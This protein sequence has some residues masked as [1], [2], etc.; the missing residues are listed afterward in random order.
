MG[1][2]IVCGRSTG[3]FSK[4]TLCKKCK[5]YHILTIKNNIEFINRLDKDLERGFKKLD[6][7][8]SRYSKILEAVDQID[9]SN[10]ILGNIYKTPTKDDVIKQMSDFLIEFNAKRIEAVYNYKRKSTFISKL[11]DYQAEIED[12]ME[13]YDVLQDILNDM[14]NEVIKIQ[15]ANLSDS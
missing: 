13:K 9:I 12:C 15:D 10:Q 6:P 4:E 11:I 14:M 8:V 3:L 5:E 2:C 7:Y 1:K